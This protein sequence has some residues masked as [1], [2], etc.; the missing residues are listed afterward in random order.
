MSERSGTTTETHQGVAVVQ[1]QLHAFLL[2][3]PMVE[4]LLLEG[5]L[6]EIDGTRVKGTIFYHF[7]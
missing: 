6:K 4:C 3:L 7:I 5:M 2:Y 1:R